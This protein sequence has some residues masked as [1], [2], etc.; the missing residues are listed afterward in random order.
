[1]YLTELTH[2]DT[3]LAYLLAKEYFNVETSRLLHLHV[4]NFL[5]CTN[6]FESSAADSLHRNS[7]FERDRMVQ[8]SYGDVLV[9][10]LPLEGRK[11]P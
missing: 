3:L 4:C 10:S 11:S 7:T 2:G 9:F 6:N 8:I 1:M 5:Y